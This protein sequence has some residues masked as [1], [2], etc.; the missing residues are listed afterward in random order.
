RERRARDC[1][2]APP[3]IRGTWATV[4]L[5]TPALLALLAKA[6][7]ALDGYLRFAAS[8]CAPRTVEAAAPVVN[9][10]RA[11]VERLR[12]MGEDVATT[13]VTGPLVHKL[14]DALH[15]DPSVDRE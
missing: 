8:R 12:A 15:D 3:R 13:F 7:E 10:L 2:I 4:P 6:D 1:R 14:A 9:A 11:N 5:D